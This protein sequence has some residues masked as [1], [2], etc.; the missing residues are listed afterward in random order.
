MEIPDRVS[1]RLIIIFPYFYS[2][3]L[4]Q[5]EVAKAA[6]EAKNEMNV[7]NP[8][9]QLKHDPTKN[10]LSTNNPNTGGNHPG[11]H[12]GN[13]P[14]N[15]PGFHQWNNI[16]NP[17]NQQVNGGFHIGFQIHGV[18]GRNNGFQMRIQQGDFDLQQFGAQLGNGL[19]ENGFNWNG[20][21][22]N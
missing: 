11:N 9:V 15:H 4:H 19:Q 16:Q 3:Q 17:G 1:P 18:Q 5:R 14:G 2:N 7:E 22:G 10:V 13:L 12:P 6:I 21:A 20:Q 8:D